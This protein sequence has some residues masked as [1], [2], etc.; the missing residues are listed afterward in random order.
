MAKPPSTNLV[1]D[2]MKPYKP[3][4]YYPEKA[5]GVSFLAFFVSICF[6]ISIFYIFNL[7]LST[8]FH[9]TKFWFAIS[10]TLILIIAADYG[11]FSSS[12]DN[13]Q[14]QHLYQ[15]Y[16]IYRQARSVSSF[17]SQYP[18]IAFKKSSCPNKHSEVDVDD[19]K[20]KNE[21]VADTQNKEVVQE[22]SVVH[23]SKGDV[24]NKGCARENVAAK[25][26]QRSKSEKTKTK[27]AVIDERK[28]DILKRSEDEKKYEPNTVEDNEFSVMSD[29]ELNRR[30][31][32]FI[33]RFNKQIRLQSA[34][35][36]S[37]QV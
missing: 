27:G 33:Q 18:E 36:D 3:K 31:E 6:Y 34:A 11:A 22:K 25:T 28:K 12:N 29:E 32:E 17:V 20:A 8:L 7:S 15:E 30:V 5:K 35:T 10:N 24:Q 23:V 9:N 4:K 13:I 37:H 1:Q 2:S 26:Y 16:M 19:M 14:D 21:E